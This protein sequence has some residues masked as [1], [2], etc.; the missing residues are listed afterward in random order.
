MIEVLVSVDEIFD[1]GAAGER[2]RLLNFIDAP[3]IGINKNGSVVV[4]L[5]D[6]KVGRALGPD[7]D[8]EG[9]AYPLDLGFHS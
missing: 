5:E 7:D 9:P 6:T 4:G 1:L 2:E 8:I 3:D